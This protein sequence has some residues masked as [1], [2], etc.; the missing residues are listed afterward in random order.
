MNI[1]RWYFL[2]AEAFVQIIGRGIPLGIGLSLVVFSLGYTYFEIV[3]GKITIGWTWPL[4][5]F[6]QPIQIRDVIYSIIA[7]L[8]GLVLITLILILEDQ[9]NDLE[10]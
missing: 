1:G 2:V 5:H 6:V 8:F 10:E 4:L 9:E 7:L 3:K